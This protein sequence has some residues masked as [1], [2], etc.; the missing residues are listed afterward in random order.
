VNHGAR[1]GVC[2]RSHDGSPA[3]H[4]LLHKC[5]AAGKKVLQCIDLPC[6]VVE[7]PVGHGHPFQGAIGSGLPWGSDVV[8]DFLHPHPRVVGTWE[9]HL[10]PHVDVL[11][12]VLA[13]Q[14]VR[15]SS[16]RARSAGSSNARSSSGARGGFSSSLADSSPPAGSGKTWDSTDGCWPPSSSHFIL[17]VC[18]GL[19][20]R[21]NTWV[22]VPWA[23]SP[24]PAR[25]WTTEKDVP[26]AVLTPLIKPGG[27]DHH[28]VVFLVLRRHCEQGK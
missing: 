13:L 7:G 14:I 9:G 15:A 27:Q 11:V 17:C 6:A 19:E 4:H 8:G 16:G 3:L 5:Y 12:Q 21:E 25:A 10:A 22:T 20:L 28:P 24:S 23:C 1:A 2:L 26:V 18:M